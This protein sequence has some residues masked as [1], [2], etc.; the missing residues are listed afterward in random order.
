MS[1]KKIFLII[2]SILA[3]IVVALLAF[4]IFCALFAKSKTIALGETTAIKS[5]NIEI[6]VLSSEKD[7][8]EDETG[9]LVIAGD[10]TKVKVKIKNNGSSDY[11]WED[12]WSFTLDNNNTAFIEQDDSLPGTIKAGATE[13]GYIYFKYTDADIM[14]YWTDPQ[15][16]GKEETKISKYYFKIK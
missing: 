14:E 2:G 7:T 6:T 15:V 5:E 11:S 8:I 12:A 10:Y 4:N 13:T 3:I 1:K 9:L 16:V